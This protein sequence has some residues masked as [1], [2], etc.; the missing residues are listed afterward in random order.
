M[1]TVREFAPSDI[2]HAAAL[3]AKSFRTA[4]ASLPL[5]PPRPD[6]HEYAGEQLSRIADHPGY[7]AWIDG[8][9]VGYMIERFT[10]ET[11]MGAPTGFSIGLFPFAISDGQTEQVCRLLY[12]SMARSWVERGYHAHQL[13]FLATDKALSSTLFHLGFGMTHFQLF[14]D[15]EPPRGEIPDVTIRYVQ[16]WDE[17]A[18]IDDEHKEYYPNPPLFWIP[19]DY[20]SRRNK[21]NKHE[22]EHT[23]MAGME[24]IAALVDGEMAGYFVLTTGTAE[25]EFFADPG[26]G[27]IK[28]AYARPRYRGMGIGKAL[29]AETVKWAKRNG[30]VRLY[31][32]GESANINGGQF[33][34]KHFRPCEYSVRRCVDRRITADMF[35]ERT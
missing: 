2:D 13:S 20:L 11:F 29:L 27:Q 17:V 28:G 18:E 9:M 3:F 1:I 32:E 26:N 5:M 14:R 16:D 10:S 8:Q 35:T 24:V 4:R 22:T 7:A 30:L 25:T 33:W 12:K 19:R 23:D 21:E 31:V 15:V 6:A 34:K